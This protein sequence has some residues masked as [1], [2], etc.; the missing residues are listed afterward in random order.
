MGGQWI[1]VLKFVLALFVIV[2]HC[3]QVFFEP[4][5]TFY[6]VFT[7]V[8]SPI[9]VPLFFMLSGYLFFSK[10]ATVKRLGRQVLRIAKLYLVW[11]VIYTP[12]I[13]K[14]LLHRTLSIYEFIKN[15]F[16]SGSYYH[17][18][19]LPA[20]IVALVFVYFLRYYL[21]SRVSFGICLLLFIIGLF[22]DTYT[23]LLNDIAK[24]YLH[25]YI[26]YFL[27]T[28]NGIFFGSVYVAAG[29]LFTDVDSNSKAKVKPAIL[30]VIGVAL[31][32]FEFVFIYAR[33]DVSVIN[34]F[35]SSIV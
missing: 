18:W 15:F 7:D 25:R 2:R 32:I 13:L 19:F 11:T 34:M 16:F 8:I 5:E 4:N 29:G 1:D 12:F 17:L 35:L 20:L 21:G 14:S 6:L 31:T 33:T 30:C 26:Y 10:E 23:F 22:G 27:T 24:E 9:A 28:R 3:G